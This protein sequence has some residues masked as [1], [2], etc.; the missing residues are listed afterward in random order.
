MIINSNS[1]LDGIIVN[2]R[3]MIIYVKNVGMDG[4]MSW[5]MTSFHTGY[6]TKFI[7]EMTEGD[8]MLELM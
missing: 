7:R 4:W 2:D 6:N 3:G 8:L 5:D 1:G